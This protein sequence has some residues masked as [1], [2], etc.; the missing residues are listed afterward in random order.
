MRYGE[1]GSSIGSQQILAK[2][3]GRTSPATPLPKDFVVPVLPVFTANIPTDRNH[4][5]TTSLTSQV[6]HLL[7]HFSFG[8]VSKPCTPG[9]H[10]NSW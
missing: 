1:I 10:Q 4:E 5:L 6:V 7:S 8:S 2:I 3:T 9:E